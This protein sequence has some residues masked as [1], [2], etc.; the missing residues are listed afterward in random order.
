MTTRIGTMIEHAGQPLDRIVEFARLAEKAG[1]DSLWLTHLPGQRDTLALAAGLA[2]ETDHV[3]VGTAITP[4]YTRPPVVMAQ[5]AITLDE[6]TGNRL[7]LGLGRGHQVFGE[8]MVG[9]T[10]TPSV[11]P[12]REY[13]TIVNSIIRRGDASFSGGF[14]RGQIAYG[15]PRNPDLPVYVG[16]FGPRMLEL[17]GELADGVILWLCTPDYLRD[18]A[19]PSLE[20][21]WARRPGGS[22]GFE[23]VAMVTA[24]VTPEPDVARAATKRM[25]AGY[26]RMENYKKLLF[27]SGFVDEVRTGQPS[28][29]MVETLSVFG[30]AHQVQDRIGEYFAAGATVLM[31]SPMLDD[32]TGF[33]RFTATME[34]AVSC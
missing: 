28:D 15:C 29:G 18:V 1:V 25:L 14:Y 19:L 8:W 34:A 31:L 13:L 6:L 7:V 12:M 30:D 26:L 21:G 22:T 11:E 4:T 24:T 27:A 3:M 33:A 16:G 20:K 2:A 32:A 5:T 17:A 9:G 23:V 10:Y